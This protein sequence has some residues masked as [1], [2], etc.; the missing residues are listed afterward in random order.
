MDAMPI[1]VVEALAVGR[2]VAVTR[3]GDMPTWVEDGV[4]GFICER[5]TEERVAGT[6]EEA[7]RRR[8]EW[9]RMGVA[10]HRTFQ[11]RFPPSVEQRFLEQLGA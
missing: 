11:A 7:W 8:A 4:S 10:A 5:A 9:A 6:L 1:A 3:I 2:P